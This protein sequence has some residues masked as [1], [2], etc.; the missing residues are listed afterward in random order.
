MF[1]LKRYEV[2]LSCVNYDCDSDVYIKVVDAVNLEAALYSAKLF[3]NRQ[4]DRCDLCN[5]LMVFKPS[6]KQ[7]Q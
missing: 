2:F 4:T 6:Q 5:E 7:I 1:S 3:N